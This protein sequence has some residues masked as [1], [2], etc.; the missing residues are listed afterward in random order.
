MGK[1]IVFN[2][3]Y[4][5]FYCYD[6]YQSV[7]LAL[8]LKIYKARNKTEQKILLKRFTSEENYVLY[9]RST[10]NSID[11]GNAYMVQPVYKKI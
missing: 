9:N 6:F 2:Y 8:L 10:G 3:L 4:G 7:R 11:L 1:I 5:V